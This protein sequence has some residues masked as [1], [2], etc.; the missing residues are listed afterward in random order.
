MAVLPDALTFA[1]ARCDH[2]E[3]TAIGHRAIMR[4]AAD[5]LTVHAAMLDGAGA[6]WHAEKARQLA[7]R[8]RA[9]AKT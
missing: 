4:E 3:A 8:L 2:Q 9:G 6:W 7:A 1:N 5:T